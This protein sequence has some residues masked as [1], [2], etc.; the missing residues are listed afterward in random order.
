MYSSDSDDD[1]PL[2]RANSLTSP[3]EWDSVPENIDFKL[4]FRKIGSKSVKR[5]YTLKKDTPLPYS[6]ILPDVG[7]TIVF[8]K[9]LVPEV[10]NMK[11]YQ[12]DDFWVF[13]E[14]QKARK[15]S[16][17]PILNAS[18]D[19]LQNN[20]PNST[21]SY[22]EIGDTLEA[23][24][25]DIDARSSVSDPPSNFPEGPDVGDSSE[26]GPSSSTPHSKSSKKNTVHTNPS[27]LQDLVGD[28]KSNVIDKCSKKVKDAVKANANIQ[29]CRKRK[30][31]YDQIINTV[32]DQ[33]ET[34]FGGVGVPRLPDMREVARELSLVY[35]AMFHDKQAVTHQSPVDSLKPRGQVLSLNSIA[36]IIIDRFRKRAMKQRQSEGNDIVHESNPK[37]GR[38]KLEYGSYCIVRFC[39]YYVFRCRSSEIKRF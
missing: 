27:W 26:L 37:R 36:Q 39:Y 7:L 24:M 14:Q 23:S 30:E 10:K 6:P 8:S 12:E 19:L 32:V 28:F 29:D 20:E 11:S 16:R 13:E 33:L 18:I 25:S 15:Y 21:S 2:Q 17:N 22:D 9:S 4:K 3:K 31:T 5:L 34:I 38:K 1:G 35:P